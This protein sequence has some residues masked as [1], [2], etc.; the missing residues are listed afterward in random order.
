MSG[1]CEF[2]N[3]LECLDDDP[4]RKCDCPHHVMDAIRVNEQIL[5]NNEN[6]K[7]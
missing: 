2:G 7:N 1:E 6:R 5:R 4:F 3:C